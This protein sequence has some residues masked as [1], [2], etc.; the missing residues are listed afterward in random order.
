MFY[1]TQK[2]AV[3]FGA[4]RSLIVMAHGL[5]LYAA[6]EAIW[7]IEDVIASMA[8]GAVIARP[9]ALDWVGAVA[10]GAGGLVLLH[11]GWIFWIDSSRMAHVVDAESCRHRDW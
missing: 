2:L 7:H 3:R 4:W 6:A 9:A 1:E 10:A 11:A 8:P 5:L